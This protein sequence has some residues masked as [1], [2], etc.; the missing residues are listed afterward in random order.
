MYHRYPVMFSNP[1]KIMELALIEIDRQIHSATNVDVPRAIMVINANWIFILVSSWHARTTVRPARI[2]IFIQSSFQVSATHRLV[3]IFHA[4]VRLV[5]KDNVAK[6]RLI[7]VTT[8][9]AN[10]GPSVVLSSMDT[11]V[12]ACRI[13]PVNIVKIHRLK[14]ILCRLCPNPSVM[15]ASFRFPLFLVSHWRWTYWNTYLVLIP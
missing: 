10:M 5:G 2:P 11:G 3:R 7:H 13:F 15:L 14:Q 4:S 1:V 6:R 12:Y 8:T 9:V